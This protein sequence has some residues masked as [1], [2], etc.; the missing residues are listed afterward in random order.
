MKILIWTGLRNDVGG[1]VEQVIELDDYGVP[2]GVWN[3]Y[4]KEEKD[5]VLLYGILNYGFMPYEEDL[6]NE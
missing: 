4:S 6:I 3:K 2:E 1:Q 5:N